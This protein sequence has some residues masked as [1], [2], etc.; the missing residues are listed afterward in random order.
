ML[1]LIAARARNG[2]IGKNNSIPWDAPED[3]KFFMRETLGG[4]IIMGRR[5][6][7]SLPSAPL[8]RRMNIVVTSR[9]LEGDVVT[10]TLKEAPDLARAAGHARIYGVGGQRIYA[11][12]LPQADRLLLTQVDVD[13]PDADAFFPAFDLAEWRRVSTLTLRTEG[14]ACTLNEYLRR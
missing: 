8:P 13:V 3:M 7:E 1:T 10:A 2:A 5:T 11:D 4:A 12:L 9:A 14:P 6:W